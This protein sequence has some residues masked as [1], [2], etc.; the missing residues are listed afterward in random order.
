[1]TS[2]NPAPG[3]SAF[4]VRCPKCTHSWIAAYLPMT[5]EAFVKI[6]THCH[7][8]KCGN[9]EGIICGKGEA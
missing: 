4:W 5:I 2:Q 3:D 9:A 8:L 1:M 6:G 7:C